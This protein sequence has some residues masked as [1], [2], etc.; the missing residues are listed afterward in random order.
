MEDTASPDIAPKIGITGT[1]VIN[2]ATNTM[3]VVGAT[4]E[5]GAYFSRLHAINIL[6][7]AEQA[8]SPGGDSGDGSR[9]GQWQFRRKTGVQPIV[10]KPTRRAELLQRLCLYWLRFARRQ[11]AVAWMGLRVRR[12][13]T[14]ADRSDMY[15]AERIWLRRVGAGAGMPIDTAA[16]GRMFLTTGNG[17]FATYPPFNASTELGESI[18]DFDLANGG[19]TPTDAFTSFNQAKLNSADPDQGSG[20]ILMCLT[21]RERT[22]TS[23]CKPARRVASWC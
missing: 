13:D 18:L 15:F 21:N 10:A 5:N 6:T 17:T 2:P 11:W 23:W 14:G 4:K 12:D 7:G 20:G 9:Y 22:R 8:N 16:G 3:Y 19:L 1:P